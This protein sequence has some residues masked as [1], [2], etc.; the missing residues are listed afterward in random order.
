MILEKNLKFARGKENRFQGLDDFLNSESIDTYRKN[1]IY[2]LNNS[3]KIYSDM[4][5]KIKSGHY[6]E[7]LTQGIYGG[8]IKNLHKDNEENSVLIEPDI[9]DD[10]NMCI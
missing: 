4:G 7:I 10:F 9:T 2:P 8:K 1:I 6:F 3:E 5:L